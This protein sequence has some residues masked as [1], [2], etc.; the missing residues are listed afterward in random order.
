M[1]EETVATTE[2]EAPVVQLSLNEIAGAVKVIDICSERGAFKGPELAEVGALRGQLANFL[3]A[4][5]PQQPP[6]G[7]APVA[8]VAPAAS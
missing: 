4:N 2:P 3:Q 1:A 8:P 7:E 6:E 5:T